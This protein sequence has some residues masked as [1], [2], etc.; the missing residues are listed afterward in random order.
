L[1]QVE[2]DAGTMPADASFF[3]GIGLLF[4]KKEPFGKKSLRSTLSQVLR[5][6]VIV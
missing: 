2:Q 4:I 3:G 5:N 6:A 1:T